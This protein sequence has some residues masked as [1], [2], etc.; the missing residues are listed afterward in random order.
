MVPLHSYET[1]RHML[2]VFVALMGTCMLFSILAA[3][4]IALSTVD[5]IPIVHSLYY[6]LLFPAFTFLRPF[7]LNS[8]YK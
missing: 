3:L 6:H 4:P 7:V 2:S 1:I 5:T 8:S